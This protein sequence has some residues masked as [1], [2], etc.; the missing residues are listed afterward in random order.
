MTKK[1]CYERYTVL[2]TKQLYKPLRSL[3]IAQLD[4][5]DKK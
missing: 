1:K 2:G 5:D 3:F 4:T